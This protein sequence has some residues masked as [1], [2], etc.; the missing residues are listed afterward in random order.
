VEIRQSRVGDHLVLHA[1]GRIDTQTSEAFQTELL[2][3]VADGGTDLIIDFAQ[4][5]YIS[6]AGF[7]ALMTA[8]RQMPNQHRIAVVALNDLVR[9]LF[10]IARFHHVI[11]VFGS[12]E[13]AAAAWANSQQS[14]QA[15]Q[16]AP[17]DAAPIRVHF[18]GTRGSLPTPV[19]Q[20]AIRAKIRDALLVARKH[21]VSSSD[22]IDAFID[23]ELPFSVRGTFGGNT[24]CVEISTGGDEYVL[25]DLGTGVREFGNQALAQ[26]EPGFKATYNVFMSHVHWD[27]IMG[28]PL[29]APAYI[30]GNTIRIHGCHS[31]LRQ[32][33]RVQHSAPWF[34]VDF[35]ALGADI[36][37][38]ELEPGVESEVAGFSVTPIKQPHS[39]NSYGYRFA[40]GGKSVIYS[41]D[42]EHKAEAVS[43]AYPFV[44]F[45]R[46]ADLL[47]FDA[48]Y[49]L[50]DSISVREDWGH[51]S[52]MVA[53]E[54]AQL[55]R[56][57]RLVLFHHEPMFDDSTIERVLGETIR[58]EEISRSGHKVEI[59]SAFDGL[60]L[61]I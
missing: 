3:V 14:Q 7:R 24:S 45:Y 54:L 46:D 30:P 13:E 49:S 25:C 21:D 9:E 57:K 15:A 6:S 47:I 5:E 37:F 10:A 36:Q 51:S 33:M 61:T 18:W 1:A 56:V 52:N 40:R 35:A 41:T 16:P 28:F 23:H 34:P 53:V 4:V 2:A 19:G 22:A 60:E 50:A 43:P 39:G 20:G 42:G 12:S 32:A 26:H 59:I 58:F 11:P 17:Q 27:H 8:T 44:E 31:V 29:F 38:V 48:M 55:A